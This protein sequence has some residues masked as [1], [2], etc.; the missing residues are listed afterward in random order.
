[1]CGWREEVKATAVTAAVVYFP[2]SYPEAKKSSVGIVNPRD[3]EA[4]CVLPPLMSLS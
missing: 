4:N 1:M 2:V 3:S